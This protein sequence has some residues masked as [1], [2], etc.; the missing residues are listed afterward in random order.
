MQWQNESI[1]IDEICLRILHRYIK[2]RILYETVLWEIIFRKIYIL[3]NYDD[4]E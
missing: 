4:D 1:G 3:C 2:H